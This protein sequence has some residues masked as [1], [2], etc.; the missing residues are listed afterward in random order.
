MIGIAGAIFVHFK[1]ICKIHGV[2][3]NAIFKKSTVSIVKI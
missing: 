3:N 2:R 1:T